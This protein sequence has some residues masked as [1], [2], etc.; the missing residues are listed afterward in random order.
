MSATLFLLRKSAISQHRD[1]ISKNVYAY[2][3]K[4]LSRNKQHVCFL[5][6]FHYLWETDLDR[7]NTIY[8]DITVIFAREMMRLHWR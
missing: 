2:L 7:A 8:A 6:G 5:F 1:G 3:L 4:A